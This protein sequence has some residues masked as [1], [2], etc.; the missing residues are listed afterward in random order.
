MLFRSKSCLLLGKLPAFTFLCVSNKHCDFRGVGHGV[1]WR[2]P[3][4]C[5]AF[6]MQLCGICHAVEWHLPHHRAAFATFFVSN[7]EDVV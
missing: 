4:S 2:L 3:T 6:A 1:V 5:V 7:S